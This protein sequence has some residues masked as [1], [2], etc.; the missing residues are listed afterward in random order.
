V[1][2]VLQKKKILLFFEKN[3]QKTFVAWCRKH[4]VR[5]ILIRHPKLVVSSAQCYGRLDVALADDADVCAIVDAISHVGA[6]HVW[7]SPLSRCRRVAEAIAA[8]RNSAYA[9]DERLLELDFGHWQGL[10]WS[11]LPQ[12]MLDSW[13][14]DPVAFAPPGGESGASL[15][16]RVTSFHAGLRDHGGIHVVIS[17]GGPLRVLGALARGRPVDLFADSPALGSVTFFPPLEHF[18]TEWGHPSE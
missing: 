9:A 6:F 17:H 18:P 16:A 3:T 7:T 11:D 12:P 2:L 5:L 14:A 1:L 10:L 15:I 8:R 4:A 13:A